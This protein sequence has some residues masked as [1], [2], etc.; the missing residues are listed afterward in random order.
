MTDSFFYF[1]PPDEDRH[2]YGYN[3][4]VDCA[5][6]SAKGPNAQVC[7]LYAVPEEKGVDYRMTMESDYC[8]C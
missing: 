8:I 4:C 5:K 2:P 6:N 7:D 1:C 3:Y